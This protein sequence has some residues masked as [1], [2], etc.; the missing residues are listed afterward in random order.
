M[1]VANT[2]VYCDMATFTAVKWF[3]VFAPGHWSECEK[4]GFGFLR[5][6]KLRPIL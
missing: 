3:I 6:N 1:A 5:I 2:L 4:F